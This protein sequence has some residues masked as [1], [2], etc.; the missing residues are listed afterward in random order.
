MQGAAE[1]QQ[2]DPRF[3]MLLSVRTDLRNLLGDSPLRSGVTI[4]QD[5]PRHFT[6]RL[7]RNGQINGRKLQ[8]SRLE[9]RTDRSKAQSLQQLRVNFQ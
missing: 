4:L 9:R 3:R 8:A 5:S 7:I 1:P 2:I 6:R